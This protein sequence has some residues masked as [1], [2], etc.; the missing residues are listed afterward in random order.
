[1][2]NN[3]DSKITIRISSK[4]NKKI[5]SLAEGKGIKKSQYIRDLIE[6][7]VNDKNYMIQLIKSISLAVDIINYVEKKGL[8]RED[9]I[10]QKKVNKLWKKF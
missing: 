7:N 3:K 1:M 10:Y 8:L 2:K 4:V 5:A 9:E 6:D